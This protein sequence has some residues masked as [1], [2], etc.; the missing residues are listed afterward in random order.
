MMKIAM[1]GATGFLGKVILRRAVERGYDVRALVRTPAKLGELQ[2]RIAFVVGSV[3]QAEK[4]DEVVAGAQAVISTVGPPQKNPGNPQDY[5]KAMERLVAAMKR[6]G[7][8]RLIHVGGA[9]H[10]G[11]ENERWNVRRRLLR[12][13][14]ERLYKPGLEAKHLE[15]EVLKE[16]DLDWTLVRP[17]RIAPRKPPG[18]LVAD[19]HNLPSLQVWVEDLADFILEQLESATWVRKAPLVAARRR[20]VALGDP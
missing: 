17:P 16:S 9:V 14:L 12:F 20:Q 4:L 19:E 13:V 15:W 8:G 1:L 7:V 10:A 3:F 18:E 5:K 11:G 2:K 6:H